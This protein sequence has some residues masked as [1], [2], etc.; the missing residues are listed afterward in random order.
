MYIV[1]TVNNSHILQISTTFEGINDNCLIN[2]MHFV[3]LSREIILENN[4][5]AD[6]TADGLALFTFNNGN[7]LLALV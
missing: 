7:I 4:S 1:S 6:L 5:E 3:E 2:S